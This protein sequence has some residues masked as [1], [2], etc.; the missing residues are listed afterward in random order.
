MAIQQSPGA[1]ASLDEFLE[2]IMAFAVANAGF[3]RETNIPISDGSN[4]ADTLYAL[5][6]NTDGQL[7][8]GFR[9]Q[10][11]NG[12]TLFPNSTIRSRLMTVRPTVAN[13]NPSNSGVVL[14]NGARRV[15]AV[16]AFN[17]APPFTGYTLYSDGNNVFAILEIRAGIFTHLAFGN[18]TKA[19]SFQGG[20]YVSGTC[21]YRRNRTTAWLTPGV[22]NNGQNEY[23]NCLLSEYTYDSVGTT[24]HVSAIAS[25]GQIRLQITDGTDTDFGQIGTSLGDGNGEAPNGVVGTMPPYN[26]DSGR[27]ANGGAITN[28]F[29]TDVFA[30]GVNNVTLRSPLFPVFIMRQHPT[31]GNTKF[32]LGT[33]DNIRSV[34]M[35]NFDARALT[36]TDWRVFPY[37]QKSGDPLVAQTSSSL[38]IAY[39]EIP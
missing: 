4:T 24:N 20:E 13:F 39:R 19:I 31:V 28:G 5:R 9:V 17:L 18:I 1:V 34:N 27:W 25:P 7:W 16:G 26:T 38:G 33:V 6:R 22:D 10:T 8:W 35:T 29:M 2:A 36:L 15:L 37:S 30:A 11:N 12:E 32:I 21:G 23:I 3:T 14:P